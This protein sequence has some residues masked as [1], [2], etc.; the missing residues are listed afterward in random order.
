MRTISV[1]AR[2]RARSPDAVTSARL[3]PEALGRYRRAVYASL[4][5]LA[6]LALIGPVATVVA[7]TI[8][9]SAAQVSGV[10]F[11][12]KNANGR[13]DAGEPGVA[14]VSVSD[15]VAL[16]ETDAQGRYE[17]E[18]D[19]DRRLSDMVFISQPSGYVLGTDE[20]MTPRFY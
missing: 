20:F 3:A 17:L 2:W 19:V 5:L 8:A 7:E 16:I 18:L 11:D 1:I 6:A 12:D 10:V 15:G 9:A 13:Q 14:G 4:A